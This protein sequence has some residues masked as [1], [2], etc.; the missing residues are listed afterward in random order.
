[1]TDIL[2]KSNDFFNVP[3]S[4]VKRITHVES[5]LK[6]LKK[7][8]SNALNDLLMAVIYLQVKNYAGAEEL[9]TK[10]VFRDPHYIFFQEC[11]LPKTIWA[12]ERSLI[13]GSISIALKYIRENLSNPLLSQMLVQ[14]F[15]AFNN[16]DLNKE[17]NALKEYDITLDLALK[18]LKGVKEGKSFFHFWYFMV[19]DI[20]SEKE[21]FDMAEK[22]LDPFLIK[23]HFENV[24]WIFNTYYPAKTEGRQIITDQVLKIYNQK[25]TSH[26]TSLWLNLLSIEPLKRELEK[27]QK[28]FEKP[29]FALKRKQYQEMLGKREACAYAFYQLMLLQDEQKHY[30]DLLRSCSN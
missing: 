27:N 19:H 8:P 21:K 29:S 1:M 15:L 6:N 7:L 9:I 11:N 14:Y 3:T 24:G 20:T 28:D 2:I 4:E 25:K 5:Y 26:E 23:N 10:I 17:L 16:E 13:I 30:L 18:E 12:K 22:Y